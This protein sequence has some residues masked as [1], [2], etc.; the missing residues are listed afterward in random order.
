MIGV[1]AVARVLQI[2][3]DVVPMS[4]VLALHILPL[5]LFALVHGAKLYR[6]RNS[7]LFI[8]LFVVVGNCF[9]NVGVATGFPFGHYYFTSA[10]G[11]KLFHVPLFLGIAYFGM[12][13]LSWIVAELIL[14]SG[15]FSMKARIFVVPAL[16]ALIMTCWDLSQEAIW[17]TVLHLWIWTKGGAYFGVPWSNF[18]GWYLTVYVI[19][20]CF[21]CILAA[22]SKIVGFRWDR[23]YSW[24]AITLY[25]LSAAGNLLLLIPHPVIETVADPTGTQWRVKDVTLAGALVSVFVM[26]SFVCWACVKVRMV[27]KQ[28][29]PNRTTSLQEA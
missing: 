12:G 1:Y 8:L 15:R 21:A 23:K 11:P 22:D 20:V 16:A 4:I 29:T 14:N 10:M 19:Y 25:A 27:S 5:L 24:A 18:F 6:L 28:R 7:V 3:L 17:S 26:G 9:E 2:F 13:Y